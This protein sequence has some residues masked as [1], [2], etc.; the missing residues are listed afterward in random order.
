MPL[1]FGRYKYYTFSTHHFHFHN[2]HVTVL[3][4]FNWVELWDISNTPSWS[5][6]TLSQNSHL[7]TRPVQLESLPWLNSEQGRRQQ[8]MAQICNPSWGFFIKMLFVWK[9]ASIA[10][11]CQGETEE[12]T[13]KSSSQEIKVRNVTFLLLIDGGYLSIT[14]QK[15]S[16]NISFDSMSIVNFTQQLASCSVGYGNWFW[17]A[18]RFC[19]FSC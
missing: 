12:C 4:E 13:L 10:G 9:Y 14:A 19:N 2:F 17:N 1:N 15:T 6:R 3:L 8:S 11:E 18:R 5:C 7:P 16:T